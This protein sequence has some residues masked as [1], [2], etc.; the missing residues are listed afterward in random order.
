MFFIYSIPKKMKVLLPLFLASKASAFVPTFHS[1]RQNN[2]LFL[3]ATFES[4]SLYDIKSLAKELNPI[5]N[6]YDPLERSEL[7]LWNNLR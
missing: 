7:D 4:T 2:T 6:F 5:V 1:V 3:D